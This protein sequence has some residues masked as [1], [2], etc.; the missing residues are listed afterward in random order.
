MYLNAHKLFYICYIER[1]KIAIIYLT[2]LLLS[3]SSFRYLLFAGY[4]QIEKTAIRRDI[5]NRREHAYQY[6]RCSKKDLYHSTGSITW[7][8]HNKEVVIDGTFYEIVAIS[9]NRDTCILKLEK[10]DFETSLFDAFLKLHDKL[11][12][13]KCRM[14]F[15]TIDVHFT[16]RS[17]TL[18]SLN[19]TG[20]TYFS[21]TAHSKTQQGFH[22]TSEQP[23]DYRLSLH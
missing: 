18:L 20:E 7:K 9:N 17:T 21:K 14:L 6:L 15:G 1:L 4:M 22:N 13:E 2:I 11:N 5:S 19:E 12:K 10:D 8:D 3:I 23:P 16:V